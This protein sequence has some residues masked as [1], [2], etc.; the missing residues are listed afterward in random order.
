[1]KRAIDHAAAGHWPDSEA[2]ASVTLAFAERFRRRIVLALDDGDEA[3]LDLDR[4]VPLADGDG[5]KL[6]GDGWI[7]V[8]AAAEDLLEIRAESPG[9]LT[10]LA[11]HIGNRH[12]TAEIGSDAIY[13]LPDHV[14]EAMI[15]GLGGTVRQVSRPFQPEGG[16]YAVSG[17]GH[18]HEHGHGRRHPR[19]HGQ[20][21]H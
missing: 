13:I 10:R 7:A 20:H 18:G 3:L 2:V 4:A 17:H 19:D 6:E 1:M 9:L 16:A 21:D 12:L 5:L 11:W 15:H 8:R 14:I